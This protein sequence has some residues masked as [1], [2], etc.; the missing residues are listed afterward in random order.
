[1]KNMKKKLAV[2][3]MAGIMLLALVGC[4]F[5]CD[6]CGETS[7]GDKHEFLGMEVCDDCFFG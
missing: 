1:M 3:A 2:L 5:T 7:S 6:L 4:S